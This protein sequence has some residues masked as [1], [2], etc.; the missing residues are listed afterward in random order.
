VFL[1]AQAGILQF[2]RVKGG[3]FLIDSDSQYLERELRRSRELELGPHQAADKY[4]LHVDHTDG[5]AGCIR[6][7]QTIT[8][9]QKTKKRLS[10]STRV[11]GWS[12]TFPPP[13]AG[14]IP[15]TVFDDDHQVHHNELG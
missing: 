3:K 12:Y 6:Q 14:A 13:P 4:S 7:E 9:H 2:S 8:A 10:T 1:R 5:N 15:T 11:E